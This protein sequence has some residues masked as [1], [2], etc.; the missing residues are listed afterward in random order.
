MRHLHTSRTMDLLGFNGQ[1]LMVQN[2]VRTGPVFCIPTIAFAAHRAT[3]AMLE[4]QAAIAATGILAGFNPNG[5][6]SDR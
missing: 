2:S 3:N 1:R 5:A 4:Q 6:T